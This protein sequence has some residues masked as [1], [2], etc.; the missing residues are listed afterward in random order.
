MSDERRSL[1][2]PIGLLIVTCG[3]LGVLAYGVLSGDALETM[4]KVATSVDRTATEAALP[5]KFRSPSSPP[6]QQAALPP[7]PPPEPVAVAPIPRPVP[8]EP[9]AVAP[10]PRRPVPAEPAAVAPPRESSEPSDSVVT[11]PQEW[12]VPRNERRAVQG[13]LA[14]L[15]F[16]PGTVD[17]SIGRLT[18]NAIR[19]YERSQGL[20]E[21]GQLTPDLASRLVQQP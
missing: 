14:R 19:A 18:R 10:V 9:G 16:D 5:A 20:P 2:V 7:Q 6:Q 17:G 11:L 8:A 21:T 4:D 13:A 12:R 1:L 3:M 15:G